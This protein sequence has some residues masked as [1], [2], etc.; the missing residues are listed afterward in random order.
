M[1]TGL[2][3]MRIIVLEYSHY[4]E[5]IAVEFSIYTALLRFVAARFISGVD[6]RSVCKVKCSESKF[7][8]AVIWAIGV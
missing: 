3:N 8:S 7:V 1:W 5:L 6:I 4:G 2:K